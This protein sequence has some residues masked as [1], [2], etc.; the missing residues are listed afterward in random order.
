MIEKAMAQANNN[1]SEAA[2]L[3][4]P[5]RGPLDSRLERYGLARARR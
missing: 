5:T 3:L 2:R 4:G 1:E